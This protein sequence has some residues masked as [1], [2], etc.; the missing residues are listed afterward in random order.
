MVLCTY[1]NFFK[2]YKMEHIRLPD[3]IPL[4]TFWLLPAGSGVWLY[5]EK[6]EDFSNVLL[7]L[8]YVF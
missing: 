8:L 4:H 7:G 1:F 3:F 2:F 5:K 6:V